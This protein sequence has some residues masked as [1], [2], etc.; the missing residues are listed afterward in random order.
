MTYVFAI[1]EDGRPPFL[2]FI[3]EMS[4]EHSH[5]NVMATRHLYA[6]KFSHYEFRRQGEPTR[7][8]D[9]VERKAA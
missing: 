3:A 4:D 1:P 6:Q 2:M 7:R 5:K 9:F 8:F